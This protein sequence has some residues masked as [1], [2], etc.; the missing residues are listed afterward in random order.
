[1][2]RLLKFLLEITLP[3]PIKSINL[4]ADKQPIN[5][6]LEMDIIRSKHLFFIEYFTF[7]DIM[8]PNN[9]VRAKIN[10]IFNASNHSLISIL[11]S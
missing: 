3:N 2:A 9:L 1:M 10:L 4:S 11:N 7:T 8:L 5:N 6:Y